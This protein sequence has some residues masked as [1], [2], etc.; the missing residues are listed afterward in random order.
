[1]PRTASGLTVTGASEYVI[2]TA[3][4]VRATFVPMTT[5]AQRLEVQ[6]PPNVSAGFFDREVE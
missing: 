5:K 1:M 4:L 6:L 3:D 2:R